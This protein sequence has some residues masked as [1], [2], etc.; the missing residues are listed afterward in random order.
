MGI[1]CAMGSYAVRRPNHNEVTFYKSVNNNN[2]SSE[3]NNPSV[4][5][6]ISDKNVKRAIVHNSNQTVF[7]GH[8]DEGK[9]YYGEVKHDNKESA[10]EFANSFLSGKKR[11]ELKES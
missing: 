1:P 8:D 2:I 10:K 9:A 11:Y 4:K 7:I 5:E 6:L 3:N